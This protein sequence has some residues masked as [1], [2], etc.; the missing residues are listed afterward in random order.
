MKKRLLSVLLILM[1]LFSMIP[2]TA[3]FAKT[4]DGKTVVAFTSDVHNAANNGS[5]DR[6]LSWIDS[7]E[8]TI[9]EIDY[10][11]MCGDMGEANTRGEQWWNFVEA[12]MDAAESKIGSGNVFY[13][14]GNHEYYN[15]SYAST[16]NAMAS[17]YLVDQKAPVPGS[18]N[19][20]LYCLGTDNWDNSQDNYTQAQIN[21]LTAFLEGIDDDDT[22]PIFIITHYPLH[23][24]QSDS[25]SGGWGS[26]GGYG[27]VTANASGVINALNAAASRGKTIIFLWGHNHSL[28][29]NTETH[30]DQMYAP[31]TRFNYTASDSVVFNFYYGAA[32]CM[33]D[34]D[35][36]SASASVIG[37]GLV[38]TIDPDPSENELPLSFSYFNKSGSSIYTLQGG[39]V[40]DDVEPVIIDDGGDDPTPS[41]GYYEI[42]EGTYYIE[43]DDDYFLTAEEGES[44]TNG[45]SGSEQYVYTGLKGVKDR[46]EATRWTFAKADGTNGYYIVASGTRATNYLNATY[47]QNDTGGYNGTLKVDDTPDVWSIVSNGSGG[48]I[49]KSTNASSTATEEKYLSHGNGSNSD[50]NNFTVRS[51]NSNNTATTIAYFDQN[52]SEVK[53]TA[54][55]GSGDTP[56]DPPSGDTVSITPST[57][58][59]EKSIRI[60]VGDTLTVNVTNGSSSSAYDYTATLSNSGIAEI[61]GNATVNIAAGSTKQF[62]VKGLAEGTV[63]VTIQNENSYGSQYVRK[64]V[65]HVTV[66]EGGQGS[67]EDPIVVGNGTFQ[68]TNTLVG[69]KRY[70]IASANSGSAYALSNPGGTSGGASMGR[71]AVT[72]ENGGVIRN[73]DANAVWTATAN[74]SRFN[75]TNGGDYLEGKSG[76]V[77]IFDSQQYADRGW[78]YSG[79]QLQHLGGQNTY[80]VY[81]S[82][83]SFTSTYNDSTDKVYLFVEAGSEQPPAPAGAFSLAISGPANAQVGSSV[84]YR[85]D[86]SSDD[87]E[88][89]AAADI[90]L[91]YDTAR[92]TLTAK[93]NC[94]EVSDGTITLLD[95]GA[96]KEVGEGIYSFTFTVRADGNA[97][98]AIDSAYFINADGATGDMIEATLI[99][100]SVTTVIGSAGYTYKAPTYSWTRNGDGY[101]VTALMECNEDAT[102]NVTET[103][104][105]ISSETTAPSCK[106][107]GERTWMAIFENG[108]FENQILKEEIP[109]RGH[110][111]GEPV[112]ENEIPAT[113]EEGGSYEEVIVCSV[114]GE[115]ISRE[116]K[117][118]AAL[119]HA[120]GEPVI[121]WADDCSTATATRT[122]GNDPDHVE[123]ETVGA[124]SAVTTQPTCTQDGKTTYTAVFQNPAFGTKTKEVVNVPAT[125]HTWTTAHYGWSTDNT[126][127]LAIHECGTCGQSESEIATA[128][129]VVTTQPTCEKMGW[130]TYI[131]E[132][133]KDGFET[134][135]KK[136]ENIPALGHDWGEPSYEWAADNTSVTATM[137]CKNDE[138]HVQ[139]ETAMTTSEITKPAT[140][141]TEGEVTYTA[142]FRNDAFETQTKTVKE[143]EAL[144]HDWGEP[145]YSWALDYSKVT[146]IRACGN[147]ESHVEFEIAQTSS[148]VKKAPS[149]EEKGVTEYTAVFRNEAFE[150]QT[151]IVADIPALGHDWGEPEWTWAED[152]SS[153]A[154]TYICAHDA[155]RDHVY[156]AEAEVSF[157][158]VDPT[159]EQDGN[160][161]WTATA[162][163]PNGR[164]VTDV[165]IVTLPASGY[166][167]AE[168]TY[169]WIALRDETGKVTGYIVIAESVCNEDPD[170]SI[171]E[172][173]HAAYAVTTEPGCETAGEGTWTAN[174][175]NTAF[176][177]QTLAQEIPA[178]GHVPGEPVIENVV[179]P[180]DEADGSHD[181][182]VYCTICGKEL[183]RE[184]VTDGAVKPTFQ[185]QNLILSG[186]IGVNFFMD[187]DDLTEEERNASYM[188]FTISGKGGAT[189]IDPFDPNH[190]NATGQYYGFTCYVK[191]IQM[192]DTITATFHYGDGTTATKTY[193]VEEYFQVF[194]EHAS[195]TNAKTA[196]LIRSI[197][198][199]GHYMQIYLA[200]VNGFTIGKDYAE[201]SRHYTESYDYAAILSKAESHAIARS[202]DGSKVE[203]ANYRLQL[204]SETTLDVFLKTTDGS[205]PTNV[206]VTVSE[207]LTGNTTTK[208]YT[209]EKQSD[210]RYLVTIPNI[211]AHKLGDVITITGDAGGSFTVKVSPLSF[212]RDVLKNNTDKE[213]RDGLAALYAYYASAAAYR[214]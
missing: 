165:R 63:D 39:Y 56:V 30:Y 209:P 124:T 19:F 36:N 67:G 181:E 95:Y 24:N 114:C 136:V 90:T 106:T 15:G 51:N 3:A 49:L 172:S 110:T 212:V 176:T 82:S 94:A 43:S 7:V 98:V 104:D 45:S 189:T 146:A 190:K 158:R 93:P 48:L 199:Y 125:G 59:P 153:A 196:A 74:G 38:V 11:G 175:R 112:R 4:A 55:E 89:F 50:S 100:A 34:T 8:N 214:G 101:R 154:V 195:E 182:V 162:K 117:T 149:C 68:L 166:T 179:E 131:A 17:R 25:S 120:W 185:T 151:A 145:E 201:L 13:T 142:V 143:I 171:T 35:Y 96:D 210:G 54:V 205:A 18:E 10:M 174:F 75:L 85:L 65:I 77:G 186:Q 139:M 157:V 21:K 156:T 132:F 70:V 109:A 187:L 180:T 91:T 170:R 129:A 103:V 164:T 127:V 161:T 134:Q 44:Y 173:A 111:P 88:T 197:A 191:S 97:R 37:K 119:G 31:G 130:T 206:T 61:Q 150:T 27:R 28:A 211:S 83:S 192:A 203:K 200:S 40:G 32:G 177:T 73:V 58:N 72:I 184:T 118:T 160:V 1:L 168:P 16:T 122:C 123:S 147:D 213:S 128:T 137:F 20:Q 46:E 99:M 126:T 6:L 121:E 138:T 26:Y 9:G 116:T 194:E 107:A 108:A 78:T 198:D 66:G 105:A 155:D 113:C 167:Y 5:R 33:S 140:C 22:R 79:N 169:E 86:L 47:E 52:G 64:G 69:G 188:E 204:G 148:V 53:P 208:A 29:P 141:E 135:T 80:T 193:S 202:L 60:N 102:M 62:T 76:E 133:T 71:T 183:S 57:D 81:Y 159:P 152:F 163:D 14:T 41:S 42:P 115:E 144:G 92:L 178:A 12:V 87:Y 2:G 23:T 207:A 84:T